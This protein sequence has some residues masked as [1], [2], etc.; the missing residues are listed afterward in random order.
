MVVNVFNKQER[1]HKIMEKLSGSQIEFQI[2]N[3]L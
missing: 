1:C 3:R 2:L